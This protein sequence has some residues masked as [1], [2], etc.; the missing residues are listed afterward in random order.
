MIGKGHLDRLVARHRAGSAGERSLPRHEG[1]EE[2]KR[3]RKEW[4]KGMHC[5]KPDKT[6]KAA[7]SWE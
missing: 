7:R 3:T 1:E 4:R 2:K 5:E 6:T